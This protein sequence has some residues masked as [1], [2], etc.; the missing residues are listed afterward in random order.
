MLFFLAIATFPLILIS[1]SFTLLEALFLLGITSSPINVA[2]AI[3][4]AAL[5]ICALLSY[6]MAKYFQPIDL[7]PGLRQ[8]TVLKRLKPIDI[9]LALTILVTVFLPFYRYHYVTASESVIYY[10]FFDYLRF[11]F[12]TGLYRPPL[13]ELDPTG[14]WQAMQTYHPGLAAAASTFSQSAEVESYREAMG[15]VTGLFNIGSIA[16]LA[17]FTRIRTV[18]QAH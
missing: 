2:T 14:T 5:T 1:V 17:I 13:P 10:V 6:S 4:I 3:K 15:I 11:F 8:S 7:T 18:Y 9:S 16:I 12:E